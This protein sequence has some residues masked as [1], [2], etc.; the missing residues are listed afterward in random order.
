MIKTENNRILGLDIVRFLAILFVISVHYF[1]NN[2]FYEMK[3]Q[4]IS[5][6]AVSFFRNLFYIC[7]PL[8]LLLT[9][10]LSGNRKIDK[11]HYKKILPLLYSYIIISIFTLIIRKIILYDSLPIF[12]LILNIF[13]FKT[14]EYSWYVNMFIGLYLL[15]PF[16]NII[17]KSITKK[18]K[19]ILILSL[20]FITSLGSVINEIKIFDYSISFSLDYWV[21]IY[22]ITY[23]YIGRY[24][25][26]YPPNIS[27]IKNIILILGYLILNTLFI[28]FVCYGDKFP[29]YFMQ[30]Y[31]NLV[32]LIIAVLVFLLFYD[33]DIKNKIIKFII[34]DVAKVSFDMYLL[35]YVVDKIVYLKF[36]KQIIEP[37]PLFKNMFIYIP[38]VFGISYL[39]AKIKEF[40]IKFINK[41]RLCIRK[42]I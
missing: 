42:N 41:I 14:I 16:L 29:N 26:E 35:S 38:I 36:G 17:Y 10:Y 15:I 4:G 34:S 13:S 18:Q 20:L 21:S 12:Q 1:L 27:K 31:G 11:N 6:I 37:A 24:F 22:P 25:N 8:F 19:K 39:L 3:M 33:L 32:T 9:G 30:G 7:V 2:N 28:Y 5:I 23:Y 40:I